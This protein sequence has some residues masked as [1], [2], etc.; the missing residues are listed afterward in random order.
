VQVE[1]SKIPSRS[2][3]SVEYRLF[4]SVSSRTA[5]RR[6]PELLSAFTAAKKQQISNARHHRILNK[7]R[8]AERKGQRESEKEDDEV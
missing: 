3:H 8:T 1:P 4:C 6:L 5:N 2:A 7:I